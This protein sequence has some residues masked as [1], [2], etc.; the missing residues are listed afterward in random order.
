MPQQRFMI[1]APSGGLQN[2]VKPWLIMDDAF[3]Q[4]DNAYVFRGRVKK[5]FGSNLIGNSQLASRLRIQVGTT[6]GTGALAGTVPG[7][8]PWDIGLML[9][10]GS[11]LYT[12]TTPGV[13]QDMLKTVSTAT[14]TFSTTNGAFVFAGAA[15]NT[16]VW[17]YPSL[18]VMG[19]VNYEINDPLNEEFTMAFDTQFAYVRDNGGWTRSA[20]GT[21]LWQGT[22]SQF[23]WTDNFTD[24][25]GGDLLFVTNNDATDPNFMRYF[26]GTTWTSFSPAF[27]AISG[28]FVVTCLIIVSFKGS[29]LLLNTTENNSVAGDGINYKNRMRY[30]SFGNA[31][32]TTSFYEDTPNNVNELFGGVVDNL[33]TQE[34]IISAEFIKDRLIVFFERSTWE[35]IY[36]GNSVLPF[37]W[38]KINTELG[39]ESTF[40]TVPFDKAILTFGETGIHSCNGANVERIDDKIP[41]EIFDINHTSQGVERVYGIRDYYSELTYWTFPDVSGLLIYPNRVLVYNYKTGSWAFND[42]TITV[43]GYFW[44]E[45]G[46]DTWENTT[47]E[48]QETTQQWN[49]AELVEGFRSIIAGNQEG[50]TFLINTDEA[51]NA[52]QLYI[53]NIAL[54]VSGQVQLT[55]INHNFYYNNYIVI[56]NAQ[57]VT[58]VNDNVYLVN[59][60]DADNFFIIEPSFAGV[61]TGGGTV[62]TVSRLGLTTKQ[63]NFYTNQER[64]IAIPK[65]YFLVDSEPFGQVS[66]DCDT[67]ASL[68]ASQKGIILDTSPYEI[69]PA[70]RFAQ[71]FWHPIYPSLKVHLY[72]F[73]STTAMLNS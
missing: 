18:P 69:Y 32:N 37:R 53:T 20:T 51:R 68:A 23:F 45:P 26:D 31:L 44:N 56:E 46:G 34:A 24:G 48:W 54:N 14:A 11:A 21:A 72:S 57:G 16:I 15:A 8:T 58:G 13:A 33:G 22:D 73:T 12:V 64:N 7:S 62:A 5:R 60:I 66:I 1:A 17:F 35:I 70:E 50:W 43:F 10:I 25:S 29:L 19:L 3:V 71:Y 36:T 6:D 65:V 27:S 49:S 40:S 52:P 9:S 42:E 38:Q 47:T 28:N 59:R 30:S 39:A 61:Y 41:N 4:M 55:V 63:Y 67:T 2:D